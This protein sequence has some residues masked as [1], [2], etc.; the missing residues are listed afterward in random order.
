ML[1]YIHTASRIF[2]YWS[3]VLFTLGRHICGSALPFWYI[4][5]EAKETGLRVF[6]LDKKVPIKRKEYS[7]QLIGADLAK[8]HQRKGFQRQEQ[9]NS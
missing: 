5:V 2:A 8:A 1:A 9:F 4:N 6:R 3:P 7:L